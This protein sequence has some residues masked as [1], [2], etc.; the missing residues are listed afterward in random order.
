MFSVK[1]NN[2]LFFTFLL[3][4]SLEL[5]FSSFFSPKIVDTRETVYKEATDC[6]Y[7][8]SLQ[9]SRCKARQ[10]FEATQLSSLFNEAVKLS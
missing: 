10:K 4:V 7:T 8:H 5:F 3:I 9:K 1:Q 6:C 2:E